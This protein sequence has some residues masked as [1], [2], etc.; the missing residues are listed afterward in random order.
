VRG[1]VFLIW[2]AR[3]EDAQPRMLGCLAP[4]YAGNPRPLVTDADRISRR[5]EKLLPRV[6][7]LPPAAIAQRH[8]V[9]PSTLRRAEPFACHIVV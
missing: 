5:V 2:A 3:S 8:D 6:I 9:R 7:V 4:L 1:K